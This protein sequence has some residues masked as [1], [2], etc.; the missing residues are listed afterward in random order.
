MSEEPQ[1]QLL[2]DWS[3]ALWAGLLASAAFYL[4]NI[5]WVATAT[6]G[7]S[8]SVVRMFGSIALGQGVLAPPA[9]SHAAALAVGLV[10]NAAISVGFT[11]LVALV[12]HRWG[13][14]V[15]LIGGAVF[16]A[17]LYGLNVFGLTKFWPWLFAL[18]GP[19]F[20]VSHLIF[21]AIAGFLYEVFEVEEYEMQ[22]AR[23]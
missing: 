11:M 19:A 10:C 22:E 20:F 16:G 6:V 1:G 2:V 15:G 13:I 12:L 3:A 8:W 5:T 23:A 7:S 14:F 4:L 17:V 21:G 9:T 18:H